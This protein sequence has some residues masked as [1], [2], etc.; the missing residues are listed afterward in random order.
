MCEN[1]AM[2]KATDWFQ[3]SHYHESSCG[4]VVKRLVY[5]NTDVTI[6]K[7]MRKLASEITSSDTHLLS[8]GLFLSLWDFT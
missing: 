6:R 7:G 1:S 8:Q 3:N 4:L 5:C 2:T